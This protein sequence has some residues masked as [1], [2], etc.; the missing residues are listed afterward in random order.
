MLSKTPLVS[1]LPSTG[2]QQDSRKRILVVIHPTQPLLAQEVMRT[3]SMGDGSCQACT[4]GAS[5]ADCIETSSTQSPR[6]HKAHIQLRTSRHPIQDTVPQT[7]GRLGIG[8]VSRGIGG[9]GNFH[10]DHSPAA[11]DDFMCPLAVIGSVS[12]QP[13]HEQ[14]DRDAIGGRS[15]FGKT[16]VQGDVGTLVASSVCV[17]NHLFLQRGLPEGCG[18]Q[19][20]LLL[21]LEGEALDGGLWAR[22][23]ADVGESRN[24][25]NDCGTAVEVGGRVWL[26]RFESFVGLFLQG[27]CSREEG[28]GVGV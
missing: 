22:G 6:R 1:D 13:G 9:A 17:W 28:I 4:V 15:L 10:D 3:R 23:R 20:D 18:L 7:I 5:R 26:A 11:C 8:R 12:I 14:N 25:E 19:V 21:A 27:L 24:T 2:P 16:D